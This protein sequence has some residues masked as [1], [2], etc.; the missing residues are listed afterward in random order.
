MKNLIEYYY[1][2]ININIINKNNIVEFEYN[3]N[4]YIF[5]EIYR[6]IEEIK[7]IYELL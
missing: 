1:G 6:K 5:K 4:T 3:N 2:L 7:E